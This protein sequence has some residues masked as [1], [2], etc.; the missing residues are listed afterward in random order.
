MR[1]LRVTEL[2]RISPEEFEEAEKLPLVVV[3]DNVR[4]LHNIG[5]VFR[6]SDAF[7]VESVYLCGIT[8]TPP[9]PDMHKTALGAEYTVNWKYI[10]NTID[11]V[12]ELIQNGYVVYS[13][14][15]AEGSVML[16]EWV[17]EKDKKYAVIFGNEVKGI[18]QE[19]IDCS[20]GCIEIPQ[21]GTKHSLN[22][23]VTAGIII[24]DLFEKL[25]KW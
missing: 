24:W 10:K 23:S 6:T 19:V 25:R 20:Y 11:A 2:H 7:R 14:E 17:L 9:H 5:S 21:F 22:V 15:Q 3:L 1:K 12:K 4:S 8:A 13:I 16:N 18:Q